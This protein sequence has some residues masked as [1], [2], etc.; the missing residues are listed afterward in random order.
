MPDIYTLR[1]VEVF[2]PVDGSGNARGADMGEVQRWATETEE[3]LAELGLDDFGIVGDGS[4][5]DTAALQAA[6]TASAGK[7]LSLNKGVSKI[8]AGLTAVAP[9]ELYGPAVGRGDQTGGI[10]YFSGYGAA[11]RSTFNDGD[12][13]SYTGRMGATF[14]DLALV[15]AGDLPR[16]S[17][18]AIRVQSPSDSYTTGSASF[19]RL[20]LKNQYNGIHISRPYMPYLEDLYISDW[21]NV[22]IL[23]D[24][25]DIEGNGGNIVG[26]SFIGNATCAGVMDFRVGY[27]RTSHNMMVGGRFGIRVRAENWPMGTCVH[28]HDTIDNFREYGLVVDNVDGEKVS[29]LTVD[30]CDFLADGTFGGPTI[31]AM[32]SLQPNDT[33]SDP[34][35]NSAVLNDL[36]FRGQLTGTSGP[37]TGGLAAFMHV[38]G[39]SG[40]VCSGCSISALT[41]NTA[42][43]IHVG[44]Q[45]RNG[46]IVDLVMQ[47]ENG[48][49]FTKYT[50]D[51]TY[52]RIIDSRGISYAALIALG[53]VANGS[54]IWVTDGN[55]NSDQTLTNGGSGVLVFRQNGAWRTR[56]SLDGQAQPAHGGTG[57]DSSAWTGIPAVIAG[58]WS[59]AYDL[60]TDGALA[61]NSD[62]RIASQK[63]VKSF[64]AAYIA[65]QDVEIFKGGIDCSGNPNYPAAD[66][67]NVYRVSV[68]GKI[69]GA[70]GVNVEV[71]DRLECFVDSSA[72]GN[73]ATVGANWI[74]SQVNIDGAVVGPS[75]ATSGNIATYNGT[76]GKLIQDGGKALPSGSILGTSDTQTLTNKTIS[77]ANNALTV[78][79]GNDV[80]GYLPEANGGFGDPA[81]GW[82]HSTPTV[83]GDG[84]GVT[85]TS[86]DVYTKTVGKTTFV[87]GKVVINSHGT[88]SSYYLVPLPN[89]IAQEGSVS[90]VNKANANPLSVTCVPT[91]TRLLVTSA[92]Y[93]LPAA[94]GESFVF[95]G[96][97]TNS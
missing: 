65:A 87:T 16:S 39:V 14:R 45:A 37:A 63:A 31:K 91:T 57:Q 83:T 78:R 12:M 6:I 51:Y 62:T 5:D 11:I 41:G 86:V 2:N 81:A 20:T 67:G 22:A 24:T 52:T 60:D 19:K 68:A 43:G 9:I 58:V 71:N 93:A 73:H 33:G 70:S 64:V 1:G 80:S 49:A 74:I 30:G 92:G 36:N 7:S 29:Q 34:Y 10:G 42:V 69:G 17:G 28:D 85:T 50:G 72:S 77:G 32:L 44:S 25:D 55:V 84:T 15:N 89:T 61:A 88:C 40:W 97:Y 38:D 82:V 94:D 27:H 8:T 48:E 46:L 18:A 4:T 76:S 75:S 47:S 79:L 66:A 21:V 96:I 59:D 56:S 90:G 26:G 54:M 95:G 3:A 35:I 13:I 23:M 53:T